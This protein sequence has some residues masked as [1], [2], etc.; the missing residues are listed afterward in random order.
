MITAENTYI[1]FKI[2]DTILGVSVDHVVAIIEYQ[3]PK[4]ESA[5]LP[6]MLGL[7]DYNDTIIPL[8]DGGLKFGAK[9]TEIK[10]KMYEM[11]I[12]F[13][14][15]EKELLMGV[16][17]DEVSEVLE[18]EGLEIQNIASAYKPGYIANGV[19][20]EDTFVMLIDTDKVFS[21]TDIF[22]IHEFLE[23]NKISN[24]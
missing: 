13:H 2:E 18:T 4:M 23:K 9:P 21:D 11:I 10:D 20:N 12:S 16:L 8:I 6:Y 17:V 3:P 22:S 1:T 24:N 14:N 5:I 15:G 7:A 19:I